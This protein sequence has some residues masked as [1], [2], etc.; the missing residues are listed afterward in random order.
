MSRPSPGGLPSAREELF[1]SDSSKQLGLSAGVPM[2]AAIEEVS[3]TRGA[4]SPRATARPI[5]PNTLRVPLS[6]GRISC[7]CASV[8]LLVTKGDAV[9]KT[10]RASSTQPSKAPSSRRS[11]S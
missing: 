10:Q 2:S 7:S 9:W 5:E 11:A 1:Q 3:T 6:A 4:A 8:T